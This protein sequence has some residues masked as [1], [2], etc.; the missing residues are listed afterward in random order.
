MYLLFFPLTII[1]WH[2]P[3]FLLMRNRITFLLVYAWSLLSFLFSFKQRVTNI[4]VVVI[5]ITF[6][7]VSVNFLNLFGIVL[8]LLFLGR[9]V[10]GRVSDS[11]KSSFLP[12]GDVDDVVQQIEKTRSFEIELVSRPDL[13]EKKRKE[14][15][16][17]AL[18]YSSA[19]S[20][21]GR[22]ATRLYRSK[23][24][25]WIFTYQTLFSTFLI[26]LVF[27]FVNYAIYNINAH[28]FR[29]EGSVNLF[30]FFYYTFFNSAYAGI[31]QIKTSS[32][33][34][35][36]LSILQI[37]TTITLI[38]T[39]SAY[40][41]TYLAERR[42]G[43]LEVLSKAASKRDDELVESFKKDLSLSLHDLKE[44]LYKKGDAAA[45]F[46]SLMDGNKG[47]TLKDVIERMG[48]N[49]SSK[50]NKDS[51]TKI[52]DMQDEASKTYKIV[53]NLGISH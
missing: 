53:C 20:Y 28:N 22:N 5:G 37:A 41:M 14:N 35:Q 11:V 2:L 24:F 50:N 51:E 21:L 17:K 29:I 34:S 7:L 43:D 40:F 26:I 52:I 23:L 39:L 18:L 6:C 13:D 15:L 3:L 45:M 12:T 16:G 25:F 47:I 27:S 30:D 31:D 44:D 9:H 48:E 42:N 8:L 1:V 36:L 10:Y 49:S 4:A 19:M 33:I 46:A 32:N 38:P